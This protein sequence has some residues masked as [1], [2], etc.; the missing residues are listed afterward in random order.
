VKKDTAYMSAL[1]RTF[2]P[3]RPTYLKPPSSAKGAA[4]TAK[5]LGLDAADL[6]DLRQAAKAAG[7]GLDKGD[8]EELRQLAR[9]GG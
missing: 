5:A 7:G 9:G 4:K 1:R 2:D 8:L 3:F 6:H